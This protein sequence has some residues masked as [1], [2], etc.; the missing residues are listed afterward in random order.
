MD[1]LCIKFQRIIA[2]K[3]IYYLRTCDTCLKI[4][5]KLPVIE[6]MIFQ[7]IKEEPITINQLEALYALTHSYEHLFNKRAKRYKELS[8][9]EMTLSEQDFKGY[10]LE[11]YTFLSRPV[12]IFDG[13]IFVGNSPKNVQ[14][15]LD[16]L[17]HE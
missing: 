10:I 14:A 17:N 11:H 8:L 5:K 6:G 3:K 9:K 7:D 16:F 1:F 15:A 4:I 13:H 12:M 2:M